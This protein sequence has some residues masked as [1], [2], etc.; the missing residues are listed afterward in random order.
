MNKSISKQ[1]EIQDLRWENF[2]RDSKRRSIIIISITIL[3]L[4]IAIISGNFW[5]FPVL[6]GILWLV[7]MYWKV[8]SK[9]T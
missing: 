8:W 1:N 7:V 6:M 2:K 9:K 5:L 3:F 4:I